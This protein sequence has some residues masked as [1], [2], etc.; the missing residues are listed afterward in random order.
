MELRSKL[1]NVWVCIVSIH[2]KEA[3]KFELLELKWTYEPRWVGSFVVGDFKLCARSRLDYLKH[4]FGMWNLT[5]GNGI[6]KTLPFLSLLATTKKNILIENDEGS[7]DQKGEG[8][9]EAA[10][11]FLSDYGAEK[12]CQR[13]LYRN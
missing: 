10:R 4:M 2:V 3:F 6:K 7:L 1:G 8:W 9:H 13:T 11:F 12:V 5:A